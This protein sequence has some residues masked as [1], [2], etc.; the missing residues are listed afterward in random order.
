[1]AVVAFIVSMAELG[2]DWA[3]WWGSRAAA[4][5]R[6]LTGRS[7]LGLTVIL[8]FLDTARAVSGAPTSVI[9]NTLSVGWTLFAASWLWRRRHDE[10]GPFETI[11]LGARVVL[12]WCTGLLWAELVRQV[13]LAGSVLA[14]PGP[15][16]GAELVFAVLHDTWIGCFVVL[17]R[18]DHPGQGGW[19][20]HV[21][22]H[23]RVRGPA[24]SI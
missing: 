19:R 17:V 2:Q 6:W 10:R 21:G 22:R 11:D 7:V 23:R 5:W 4:G 24:V 14:R 18:G 1:V 15:P 13:M 16:A 9:G 20:R 3:W 8:M 12:F